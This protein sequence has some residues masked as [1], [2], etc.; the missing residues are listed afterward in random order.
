MVRKLNFTLVE[1]LVVVMILGIVA[2]MLT[3][4]IARAKSEAQRAV[5]A[6]NL[7]HIYVA[8]MQYALDN[9]GLGCFNYLTLPTKTG[10]TALTWAKWLNGGSEKLPVKPSYLSDVRSFRCAQAGFSENDLT[11]SHTYGKF[12]YDVK[13]KNK[14]M[15]PVGMP[16]AKWGKT[17]QYGNGYF[18]YNRIKRP[19]RFLL[20]ADTS[21]DDENNDWQFYKFNPRVLVKSGTK[22]AAIHLRHN[23]NANVVFANGSIKNINADNAEDFNVTKYLSSERELVDT[24]KNK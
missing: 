23:D 6:N 8:E 21:T 16:F 5:C 18:A 24:E 3:P 4:M 9:K 2:A 13:T 20:F 14:N 10:N 22:N 1:L 15:E 17:D 19:D 7:K 12:D 11:I